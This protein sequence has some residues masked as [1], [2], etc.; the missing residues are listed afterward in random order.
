MP[1]NAG[2][3][4][5][6]LNYV[7]FWLL[8][9]SGTGHVCPAFKA[10]S[11]NESLP[12]PVSGNSILITSSFYLGTGTRGCWLIIGSF[13]VGLS[14][15]W[16]GHLPTPGVCSSEYLSPC[17]EGSFT[18]GQGCMHHRPPP[19]EVTISI[20]GEPVTTHT[21]ATHANHNHPNAYVRLYFSLPPW[22]IW[23]S[24]DE[25]LQMPS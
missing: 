10:S 12:F 25:I 24:D 20:R 6:G 11:L 2:A 23:L 18:Y 19:E 13:N 3:K 15:A 8:A 16:I 14:P 1:L 22:F 7:I 21:M 4:T 5:D 9:L 17:G